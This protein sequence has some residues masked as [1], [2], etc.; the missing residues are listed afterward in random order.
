M[1]PINLTLADLV[2]GGSQVMLEL[3]LYSVDT[4]RNRNTGAQLPQQVG[5]YNVETAAQNLVSSNQALVN[6]A[7]AEGLVPAGSSNTTIALALIASGL[8]QSTLLSNTIGFFGG[9]ITQSGI[10]LNAVPTF[11]LALNSTDTRAMDD[12]QIRVGDGQMGTF[13]VGSRYPIT[14][15]TYTSSASSLNSSALAGVTVNGVSAASLLN[16]LS[17]TTI[18]QIQYEDLGFTLKATPTV[19]K[20]GNISMHLDF[21]IES[22]TGG[23]VNGIPILTSRQFVSDVTVANGQTA[24]LLSSVSKSEAGAISGLPGLSEVPGFQTTVADDTLAT[25]NSEIILLVTPH[26]VR[27]RSNIYA[28]PRI[29]LSLPPSQD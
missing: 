2:D 5:V 9:G 26:I 3:K 7:I 27:R 12:L 18:P 6:Q 16:T 17:T 22:L 13:R 1:Q 15:S 23:S 8:V 14:T 21:K 19:Q 25:S 24:T 20:S 4:T 11:N 29:A 28:G 10:T